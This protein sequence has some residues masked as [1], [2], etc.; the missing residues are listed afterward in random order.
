[1]KTQPFEYEITFAT[2]ADIDELVTLAHAFFK[3]SDNVQLTGHDYADTSKFRKFLVAMLDRTVVKIILAKHEGRI[4][5]Y[6]VAYVDTEYATIGEMYQFYVDPAYRGTGV[7]RELVAMAVQCYDD[8]GCPVSYA[9][10]APEIGNIELAH[11]RNLFAKFGY[12]ETGIIM[13]RRASHGR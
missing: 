2:E 9:S 6:F 5:G 1:M 8:W 12:V 7:S 4:V 10:A 13:T 11:F 3:S